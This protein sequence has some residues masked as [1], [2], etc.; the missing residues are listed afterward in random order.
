[1]ISQSRHIRVPYLY[2][3][4]NAFPPRYRVRDL[5]FFGYLFGDGRGLFPEGRDTL[6][7]HCV[8]ECRSTSATDKC[9]MLLKISSGFHDDV[10]LF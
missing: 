6:C 1:M 2:S 7:R 3:T 5:P 9:E 4:V 8:D 10:T